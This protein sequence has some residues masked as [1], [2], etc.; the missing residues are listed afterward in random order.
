MNRAQ[1]LALK[2]WNIYQFVGVEGYGLKAGSEIEPGR[3]EGI[4]Q[5]L[6]RRSAFTF[7]YEMMVTGSLNR[8][9]S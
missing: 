7:S 5:K 8:I 1:G 6:E 2:T 9:Y 4:R 3:R